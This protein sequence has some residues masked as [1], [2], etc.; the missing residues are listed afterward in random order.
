M[1]LRYPGKRRLARPRWNRIIA[2]LAVILVAA[3]VAAVLFFRPSGGDKGGGRGGQIA[4]TVSIATAEEREITATVRLAGSVAA[5]KS[6]TVV[7]GLAG[8]VDDVHVA[9]GDEVSAG[10]E[11][12]HVSVL[13][14]EG[15]DTGAAYHA[16]T[17]PSPSPSP[18]ASPS[19]T[20]S[21]RPTTSPS[22]SPSPTGSA[23]PTTTPTGGKSPRPTRTPGGGVQIPTP[24][25]NINIP[26]ISPDI[27]LPSGSTEMT[28]TAPFDGRI[29]ELS[30]VEGSSVA[31]STVIAT[32]SGNGLEVRADAA[33]TQSVQ[34]AKGTGAKALVRPAVPGSASQV[35]ARMSGLAPATDAT[36]GQTPVLLTFTGDDGAFKPGD[37]VSVD[38]LLPTGDGIVVP[39]D[40]VLY[41]D[42]RP[43]VFV[44]ENR[45]D[46][47]ALG[48]QLPANLPEGVTIGRVRATPVELG[49]RAGDEQQVTG[50][51]AGAA[52]VAVGQ[53]SLI[54]GARVA[55]LTSPSPATTG[56]R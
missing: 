45:I 46:P 55:I 16:Y 39:S 41:P 27:T 10:D 37:P 18:S 15:Q 24:E 13:T 38:V 31:A 4:G 42:G 30:I 25:F 29:T 49:V 12:A 43:A 40:A 11:I 2:G 53:S 17:S 22:A 8:R 33:P 48:V 23:R 14:D 44:V 47:A 7:A 54:D 32:V 20:G 28:V 5:T 26:D 35:D 1:R 9:L 34:L 6:A 36:T 50:V 52:V 3:G 21:A 19:P 56:T 51:D